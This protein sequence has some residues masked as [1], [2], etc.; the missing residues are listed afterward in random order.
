VELA[1]ADAPA[2]AGAGAGAWPVD[3][4]VALLRRGGGGG[5]GARRHGLRGRFS[6]ARRGVPVPGG[7][8]PASDLTSMVVLGFSFLGEGMGRDGTGRD[9]ARAE[10]EKN[11]MAA[12]GCRAARGGEETRRDGGRW[13]PLCF[14]FRCF[15]AAS[16]LARDAMSGRRGAEDEETT[17]T[18]A[19]CYYTSRGCL[20]LLEAW[21][22]KGSPAG[23]AAHARPARGGGSARAGGR[24]LDGP[25]P[26]GRPSRIFLRAY[27]VG[28]AAR[29]SPSSFV[30]VVR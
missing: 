8:G 12:A 25:F 9:G 3:A 20:R 18:G 4:A 16:A 23:G 26:R 30:P 19:D 21:N 29:H 5:R 17:S 14:R 28:R 13:W 6:R 1:A 15:C 27:S 11:G 24:A 7:W 22:L 10:T 2:G